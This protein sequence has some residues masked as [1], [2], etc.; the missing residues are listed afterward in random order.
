MAILGD[1]QDVVECGLSGAL[2]AGLQGCDFVFNDLNQIRFRRKGFV[3]A[4]TADKTKSY[5]R[6]KQQSGDYAMILNGIYNTNWTSKEIGLNEAENTRL[7]AKTQ[8]M[9]YQ[10]EVMLD[11]G[12]YDAKVLNS[13]DNGNYDVE[14]VD[15]N[16]NELLISTSAGGQ[17]GLTTSLIA[18]KG[19]N[20]KNGNNRQT[21]TLLIQFASSS[22][23]NSRLVW[24][25]VEQLGYFHDEI[26]DP[27]QVSL[28]IPTAPVDSATTFDVK[29]V[30][31]RGGAFVSGLAVANFLV[32]VNGATVTPSGIAADAD[33]KKYTFTVSALSTSDTLEVKVYDSS[34]SSAIA[35]LNPGDDDILYKSNSA[36]SVVAAS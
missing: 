23:V 14:L 12:L 19:I 6:T 10:V 18:F 4:A 30:L 27:N 5:I 25:T 24:N 22:E 36:T 15:I 13:I 8:E 1:I 29:T 17:K 32:K 31:S 20:F 3:D 35:I 34:E 28:S 9:V 21:T 33:N 7:D 2:G 16:G 11:N 26:T